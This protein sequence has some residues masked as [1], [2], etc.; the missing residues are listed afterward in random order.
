MVM[1][2]KQPS[3]VFPLQ[4]YER[5]G[6]SIA[7]QLLLQFHPSVTVKLINSLYPALKVTVNSL[8][9]GCC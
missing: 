8:L 9:F 3:Y 7:Y 5:V 2:N 6:N 4:M 1:S